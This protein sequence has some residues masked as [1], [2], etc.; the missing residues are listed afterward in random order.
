MTIGIGFD[1]PGRRETLAADRELGVN[2]RASERTGFQ[3]RLNWFRY[4]TGSIGK[5]EIEFSAGR[6]IN[7]PS[8]F[9]SGV[10]DWGTYRKSGVLERMQT[11][12]CTRMEGVHLIED[13]GHWVQQEQPERVNTVLM[14]FLRQTKVA[15]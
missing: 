1:N 7:M 12:T 6:T 9:I 2:V 4:H 3:G 11:A 15:P 10:A 14:D 5:T 8:C 13:A